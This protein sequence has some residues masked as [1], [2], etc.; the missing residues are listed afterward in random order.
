MPDTIRV[1]PLVEHQ[2]IEVLTT[3]G[4]VDVVDEREAGHRKAWI[5]EEQA[6]LLIQ[7]LASSIVRLHTKEPV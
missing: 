1:R 7:Q 2:C 5:S 3:N 6:L 4:M